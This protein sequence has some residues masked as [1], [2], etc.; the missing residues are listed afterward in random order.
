MDCKIIPV[1]ISIIKNVS[2]KNIQSRGCRLLGNLAK[3]EKI[4]KV[5]DENGGSGQALSNIFDDT[6]NIGVQ[7]MAVRLIRQLWNLKNFQ[8]EFIILGCVKKVMNILIENSKNK[9]PTSIVPDPDSEDV[10]VYDPT[11]V[12]IRTHHGRD[13]TVS[14]S[15]FNELLRNIETN[16]NS[17]SGY[18]VMA[19]ERK[20][21]D[22][23]FILPTGKELI[24]LFNGILKCFQ[25]F[26]SVQC[27]KIAEQLYA[28]GQGY[29]CLVF[30]SRENSPYRSQSLKI[31]SN[32]VSNAASR[33][34]LGTADVIVSASELLISKN[35]VKPLELS[36]IKYCI[37]II[38]LLTGDS[39]NRAK[40]R[41]SGALSELLQ[42]SRLEEFSKE[43]KII[44]YAFYQF[45]FDQLSIEMLISQGLV[46]VLIMKLGKKIEE[47]S[48]DHIQ[49][50]QE[51]KEDEKTEDV[52][53]NKSKRFKQSRDLSPV[54]YFCIFNL[55]VDFIGLF[56]F[57][58]HFM[59]HNH[60]EAVAVVMQ[61]IIDDVQQVCQFIHMVIQGV[62]QAHHH[63]LQIVLQ[64]I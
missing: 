56:F 43:F 40:I 29:L 61:V 58:L 6:S 5:I 14:R 30:L 20:P 16:R 49:E 48:V 53:T 17:I 12:K 24:D 33:C 47:M 4:C 34:C 7:L 35:L 59:I 37:R 15:K 42:K 62:H 23:T 45:R 28:D 9:N 25:M 31:L 52:K 1:L 19:Q 22:D 44:L 32:L 60:L 26:T 54:S 57:S 11:C 38:C 64:L 2:N 50:D 8:Y 46:E 51:K 10:V 36:E 41:R 39:C 27:S 63:I 21:T 18:E 13:R 3:Y 55:N